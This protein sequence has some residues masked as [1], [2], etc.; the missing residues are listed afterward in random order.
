MTFCELSLSQAVCDLVSSFEGGPVNHAFHFYY[1]PPLNRL[2]GAMKVDFRDWL[3]IGRM[4]ALP[5]NQ[6]V[7]QSSSQ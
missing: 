6:L 5:P 1:C 3:C 4:R 2:L 7:G